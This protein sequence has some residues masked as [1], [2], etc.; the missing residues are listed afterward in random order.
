MFEQ[1]IYHVWVSG[2][3]LEVVTP[4]RVVNYSLTVSPDGQRLAYRSVEPRTMGDVYLK[5]LGNGS[6]T[7]LTEINPELHR[8]DLGECTAGARMTTKRSWPVLTQ[9][10]QRVSLIRNAWE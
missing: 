3:R 5:E 4:G 1:A 8:I 2:D 10:L 7:R 9:W 6:V